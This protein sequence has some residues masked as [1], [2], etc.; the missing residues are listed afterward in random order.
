[1]ELDQ[2]ISA[3]AQARRAL[4]A[5][6]AEQ[7]IDDDEAR[8]DA[9]LVVSELVTNALIHSRAP[10]NARIGFEAGLTADDTL[11]IAVTDH[12]EGF[13]AREVTQ[14]G[15]GLFLLDKCASRWGIDRRQAT[16]VWFEMPIACDTPQ[17]VAG[18]FRRR[19][20]RVLL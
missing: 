19:H 14:R 8:A 10:P 13:A 18:R 7:E 1:L 17:A 15:F 4:D 12:G 9:L 5:M 6:L 20:E 16:R 3:P 11:Q 2:T